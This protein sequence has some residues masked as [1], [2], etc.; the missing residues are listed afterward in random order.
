MS[1]ID[2]DIQRYLDALAAQQKSRLGGE[3]EQ[4][5]ARVKTQNDKLLQREQ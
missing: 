5:L 4:S 2:E 1:T 3:N